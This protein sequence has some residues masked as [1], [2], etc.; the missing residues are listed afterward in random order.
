MNN[1]L[2]SRR[3]LL[4]LGIMTSTGVAIGGSRL[5]GSPMG[6]SESSPRDLMTVSV[7]VPANFVGMHFHRWPEGKPVS[8]APT[9][10]Y[11][12]V[13]SHDYSGITWNQ[14]H[15]GPQKFE[16]T[17]LDRWVDYYAGQGKSLIYVL[18]GTPAWLTSMPTVK[19]AYGNVGGAAPPS[20]LSGAADFIQALLGRYNSAAH[21]KVHCIE[22]WNEPHF[23][24]DG[25]WLG[26]P[27]QLAALSRTVYQAAKKQDPGIR[28][29]S[30]GWDG[31][32]EGPFRASVSGINAG[33]QQYLQADDG[34]GG[35]GKQWFD[36][37][38]IHTYNSEIFG[39]SHQLEGTVRQ[40]K[41]TLLHFGRDVPIWVTETGFSPTSRVFS[42]A[43]LPEKATIIRQQAAVQAALGMQA[44]CFY[45]HDDEYCGN[46]SINPIISTAINDVQT[47]LAGQSLTQVTLLPS[48]QVKV[49]T[50][51][52]TFTW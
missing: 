40:A 31:L 8:A 9:Y 12:T 32:V 42:K 15:L 52:G 16:W 18:Y 44:V 49:V 13:R 27:A 36:V 24:R 28:I 30:P 14:V 21:R 46:P 43:S 1:L 50:G 29:I 33:L 6:A 47:H 19:D 34:A 51:A 4:R 39:G 10:N 48:S 5:W 37:F 17:R 11:G 35:V 26:S 7:K 25:F 20:D 23:M 22:L 2:A 3:E 45:A 41:E 38:A